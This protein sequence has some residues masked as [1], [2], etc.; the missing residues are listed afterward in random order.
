M[1]DNRQTS[2]NLAMYRLIN[3]YTPQVGDHIVKHGWFVRTKWYGVVGAVNGD[4]ISVVTSGI[5][6]NLFTMSP[7]EMSANTIKLSLASIIGSLPGSY[8]IIKHDASN[9]AVVWYI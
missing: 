1:V 4:I 3:T 8:S 7:A 5:P 2:V 6:R 9:N